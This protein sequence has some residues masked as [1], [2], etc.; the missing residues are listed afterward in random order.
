MRHMI[1]YFYEVAHKVRDGITK[2]IEATGESREVEVL[3][4][5]SRAALEI[6]GV[7]GLGYSFESFDPSMPPSEYTNAV[8][9]FQ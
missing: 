1:P 3:S 2:E 6:I 8:K 5:V 7:A 4:W 9:S